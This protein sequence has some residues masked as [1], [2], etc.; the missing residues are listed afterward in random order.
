ML[1]EKIK[2]PQDLKQFNID[3]LNCLSKEIRQ[4]LIEVVSQTGGHLASS[5]GAVELIVA[6]HYCLNAPKD[7]IVFDVG[8][9]AYAHK[10]L[11]GRNEGFVTLRQYQGLSGF[12]SKDESVYDP[13]TTGHSSNAVSLALGLVSARDNLGPDNYFKVTAVI[14]DG[15]L[16]GGLCFEGLNNAGHLKKDILIILNTNEL[17]IAPNAGSLSTYLNKVISLPLYNRFKNSLEGFV[18]SRIPKG[19][20]ILKMANKFEEGLKGLFVPG[21]FFEEL[22]FRYF[23]PLDGH[24]LHI[25]IPTLKNILSIKGP[26]ILHVVTKKGKGYLPA[27]DDPVRFH[28]AAKFEVATGQPLVKEQTGKKSYTEVFS[29]KI[30]Q[31]AKDDLKIIAITAAMPEGTGLDKFRD[32]YAD[33]FFDVGIAEPHAVCFAAGLAAGGFKPV[34]AIYST[35]LQRAYDQIIEDVALQNLPVVFAIDRSGIVGEDGITHQGIFDISFLR[36]IPN[37]TVM[38]PKDAAELEDMLVFAF[39]LN[40]PVAIRY[41]RSNCPSLDLAA[42][43]KIELGKAERLKEGKDFVIIAVGSMVAPC[44]QAIEALEKQGL[45]GT[46]INARFIS[47][48]DNG[49]FKAVTENTGFIFTVEEGIIPGGFGSAVSESLHKPVIKIG[50]PGEFIK[51]GKRDSLLEKYGLTAAGIAGR[52]KTEISVNCAR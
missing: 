39:N 20:R 43:S 14:G 47:P 21:M 12:P 31:L 16:S 30:V 50:L 33:R 27:E 3:E 25:L 9:Q 46:L 44:L 28:G 41:P 7:K 48:L 1:L 35:F 5:L 52:I 37:L 23:G 34:V 15:S 13:F 26:R 51:H 18:Q 17:S 19:G 36:N 6:L 10:I 42:P 49:L 38:A 24:N 8:H 2:S 32:S 45:R 40:R 22:G 11:T 29:N 4:R